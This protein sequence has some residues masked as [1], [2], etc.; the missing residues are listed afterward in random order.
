MESLL[1]LNDCKIC[2]KNT[3]L[4]PRDNTSLVRASKYR[5][6]LRKK[7]EEKTVTAFFILSEF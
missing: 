6:I 2:C 3:S 5:Y 1:T 4:K 7:S